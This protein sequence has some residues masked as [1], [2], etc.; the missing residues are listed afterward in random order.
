MLSKPQSNQLLGHLNIPVGASNSL[1]ISS[2]DR[3]IQ[4]SE[5]ANFN[6]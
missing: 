2:L 4:L 3:A 5:E 6:L 1:Y